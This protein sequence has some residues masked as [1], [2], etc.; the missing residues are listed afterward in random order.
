[1]GHAN[2]TRCWAAGRGTNESARGVDWARAEALG[3]NRGTRDAEVMMR[4][5]RS[6]QWR[7]RRA[8]LVHVG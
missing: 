1:M 8:A 7:F 3:S 2:D 6:G 5:R 4:E